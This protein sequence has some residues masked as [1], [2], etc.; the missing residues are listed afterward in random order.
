VPVLD[1]LRTETPRPR[2]VREYRH[3]GRLAVT[4]VC[5]A[6]FIGRADTGLVAFS[7]P[8]IQRDFGAP[9]AATQWVSLSYLLA[10]AGLV[11]LVGHV[12]EAA[13]GKLIFFHGF[14]VLTVASAACG[15]APSLGTLIASRML[16]AVG[17]AMLQ[18]GG[19]LVLVKRVPGQELRAAVG[20]QGMAQALGLAAGPAIGGLIL[21]SVGWRWVFL[22]NVPVGCAGVLAARY[23]L[24]RTRERA[25]TCP[26]DHAGLLWR[27]VF[28]LAM[29]L[30][31]TSVS[32][33]TLFSGAPEVIA[34]VCVLS[35]A[36]LWVRN[37]RTRRLLQP[38]P[39][40]VNVAWA[41]RVSGYAA[42][43]AP[44]VLFS[45]VYAA[46]AVH[47]A[48][49]GLTVAALPA[50]F[51]VAVLT[52]WL[53]R[54]SSG[55]SRAVASAASVVC[56]ATAGGLAI[57]PWATQVSGLLLTGLGM[58]LGVLIT[59]NSAAISA[60]LCD[61][62]AP[63][64]TRSWAGSRE[65]G[66]ALGV[67]AVTLCLH[68]SGRSASDPAGARVSLAVLALAALIA[69]ATL[70]PPTSRKPP[71]PATDETAP[72]AR[73]LLANERTFL[74]WSRTALA[75]V[76]AGL[77]IV[78]LLHPFP[79]VPWGRHLLGV[80]LITLGAVVAAVG[81]LELRRNQRA[82]HR[83]EPLP[84]S[85]LPKILTVAITSIAIVSAVVLVI[86]AVHGQ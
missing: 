86:S 54:Y 9:L 28:L 65:V 27:T 66:M 39:R 73:F 76:A 34:G 40:P 32:G 15:L 42:L 1:V 12:A 25:S 11:V 58:G 18:G 36:L 49:A 67:V 20:V 77:A 2:A 83:H 61:K 45:Q 23:L 30:A 7:L 48:V 57:S 4:T 59:A 62:R 3:A 71:V 84:R 41:G 72:D 26:I 56:V 19:Y 81:Y 17:A 37:R 35:G 43:S 21:A 60:P 69:G 63:G 29:L 75:L 47:P 70:L 33:L 10:V 52:G 38:P 44:L 8:A 64:R 16:Q 78:Q 68:L 55:H 80:S 24:P 82:L 5:V 46:H 14:V 53:T 74:A 22:I 51:A 79:G 31:I 50:G 6:S 13:G 85:A